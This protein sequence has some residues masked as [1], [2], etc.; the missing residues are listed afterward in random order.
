MGKPK[1]AP[2]EFV[3]GNFFRGLG[4]VPAAG[5]LIADSDDAAGASRVAVVSYNYW[6]DRF[7]GDLAAIGQTISINN[8]PFTIA[9][10][11]A[12]EFF[13]VTPGS[14]PGGLRPDR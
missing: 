7:G 10:V 6:R 3:S 14:A 12:P 8:T 4:I 2:V 11:A 5:R 1:S 13:G 9:G